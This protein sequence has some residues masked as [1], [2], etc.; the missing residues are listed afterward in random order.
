MELLGNQRLANQDFKAIIPIVLRG[1]ER[2]FSNH[3]FS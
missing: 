3:F 2:S 1:S